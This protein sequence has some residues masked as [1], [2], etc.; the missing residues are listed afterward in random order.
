MDDWI[1]K[2]I[3]QYHL[4]FN[5]YRDTRLLCTMDKNFVHCYGIDEIEICVYCIM[6]NAG[7]VNN[8]KWEIQETGDKY[9]FIPV[10]EGTCF[11]ETMQRLSSKYP[12]CKEDKKIC[13]DKSDLNPLYKVC[14]GELLTNKETKS[15]NIVVDMI[16]NLNRSKREKEDLDNFCALFCCYNVNFLHSF[17]VKV[18]DYIKQHLTDKRKRLIFL[19]E[20]TFF[21]KKIFSFR[22]NITNNNEN[23]DAN[24]EY[25]KTL[26]ETSMLIA[27]LLR[28]RYKNNELALAQYQK[29]TPQYNT[30]VRSYFPSKR[31]WNYNARLGSEESCQKL[32]R[33]IASECT[34]KKIR[35][36]SDMEDLQTV[37]NYLDEISD[38]PS[39]CI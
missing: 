19:R 30:K 39:T 14:Q 28:Q 5:D 29:M 31:G 1:N 17:L 20:V 2:L 3:V 10:M 15:C 25:L 21:I 35:F 22:K 36:K 23:V 11:R 34:E 12:I 37:M 7:A 16:F 13:H 38:L 9:Y 6:E 32:F 33:Q 4:I 8:L 26:K 18:R 27:K 24:D